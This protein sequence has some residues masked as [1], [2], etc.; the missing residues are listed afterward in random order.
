LCSKLAREKIV[1]IVLTTAAEWNGGSRERPGYALLLS[2]IA[3]LSLVVKM[4]DAV[5]GD[6]LN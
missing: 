3:F 1:A 5:L 4:V 6:A 2:T